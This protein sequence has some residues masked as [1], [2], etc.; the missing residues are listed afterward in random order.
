MLSTYESLR[1]LYIKY[2]IRC[3]VRHYFADDTGKPEYFF[4][5]K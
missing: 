5:L 1:F 3:K 4:S 2:I